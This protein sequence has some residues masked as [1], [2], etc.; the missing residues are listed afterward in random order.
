[1][2]GE[3]FCNSAKTTA[4]NGPDMMNK[5]ILDIIITSESTTA[6]GTTGGESDNV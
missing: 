3:S 1:M 6:E 5:G 2:F 4:N